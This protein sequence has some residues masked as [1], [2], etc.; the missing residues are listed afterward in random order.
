MLGRTLGSAGV[1]PLGRSRIPQSLRWGEPGVWPVAAP[2]LRVCLGWL[3]SG[4]VQSLLSLPLSFLMA[5]LPECGWLLASVQR[6]VK[7]ALL[8]TSLVGKGH[9]SL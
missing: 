5:E 4:D 7:E 1:R 3:P 9:L 6:P 2:C 8:V